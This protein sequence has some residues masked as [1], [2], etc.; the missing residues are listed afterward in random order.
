MAP[1]VGATLR[2]GATDACALGAREEPEDGLADGGAPLQAATA[3]ALARV[4]IMQPAGR[5]KEGVG[6]A[7]RRE[8]PRSGSPRS[9]A[10]SGVPSRDATRGAREHP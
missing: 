3:M 5:R 4:A 9:D 2:E 6:M 8:T 10:D 1:T 7:P